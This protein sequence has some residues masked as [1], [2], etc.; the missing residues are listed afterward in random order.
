MAPFGIL[1]LPGVFCYVMSQVLSG[2]DFCLTY[3][4]NILI[5]SSSGKEHLYHLEVEVFFKCLKDTNVK[6]KVKAS[7]NSLKSIFITW[8]ILFLSKVYNHYLK[9]VSIIQHI[10]ECSNV[11]ELSH[12]LGLTGYYRKFV[13]LFA[14]ITKFL[15]KHLR[16]D[17]KF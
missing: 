1:S 15:N 14:N 13:P 11:E 5:H 4:K 16:K 12:I 3:L 2:I 8:G 17:T 7:A 9:K 10:K 6:L